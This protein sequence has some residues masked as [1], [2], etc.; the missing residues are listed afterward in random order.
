[1]NIDISNTVIET[2]RLILRY[3]NDND[4]SDFYEYAQVK[5]VGEMA[6][7]HH[8]KSIEESKGILDMFISDKKIFAIQLK[9]SGKVIGSLGLQ[10]SWTE[11]DEEYCDLK[12]KEIGYVLSKD[13]WGKGLM[14]EAVKALI[15][16]CFKE[17]GLDAVTVG[18]FTSNEQSKRVIK[19]CGFKFVKLEDYYSEQMDKNFDCKKYI[20]FR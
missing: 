7:W 11:K 20:L 8:H 10:N 5:G 3:W 9:K 18:H 12:I 17:L 13:Y 6:G 4:L 16:Y 2:D 15:N 1:M 14:P 19:K